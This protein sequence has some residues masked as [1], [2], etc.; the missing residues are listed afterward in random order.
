MIETRITADYGN[1]KPP[2]G[3]LKLCERL[4]DACISAKVDSSDINL[5]AKQW[6]L[7]DQVNRDVNRRIAS[8]SDEE[9]YGQR[10]FWTYPTSA[11]DCEDYVLLKRRELVSLGFPESALLITV[12]LDERREGHA[13][14]TVS[15]AAGDYILDNRR[16]EILH[17][18]AVN[19]TFLKRQAAAD[20]ARWI[21]LA[22]QKNQTTLV[23]S[24]DEAP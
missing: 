22:P 20:P 13:V 15:T 18:S 16:D 9:L 7:V 5:S 14:L 2:G 1:A 4:P 11:G 24:G 12:V 10:E 17:W 6:R 21:A 3:F 8:V 19:Y 23:A